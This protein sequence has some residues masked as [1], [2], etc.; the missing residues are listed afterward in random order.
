MRETELG[1]LVDAPVGT[2]SENPTVNC[3]PSDVVGAQSIHDSFMER[4]VVPLV[5]FADVDAHHLGLTLSLQRRAFCTGA[6]LLL[7]LSRFDD[8]RVVH[9]NQTGADHLMQLR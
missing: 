8:G 9:F 6:S 1:I 4:L 2:V 3:N 5:V 7:F